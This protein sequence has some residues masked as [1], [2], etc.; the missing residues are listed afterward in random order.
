MCGITD[1]TVTLKP[2]TGGIDATKRELCKKELMRIL[3]K[4][5]IF[6]YLILFHQNLFPK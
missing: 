1:P 6:W 4:V 2:L 5:L 3:K